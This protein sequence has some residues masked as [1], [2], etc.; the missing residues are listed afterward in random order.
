[1]CVIYPQLL[2][3]HRRLVCVSRQQEESPAS[4]YKIIQACLCQ[5][6]VCISS[7]LS[8]P[9]ISSL[10]ILLW[11]QLRTKV[12][13]RVAKVLNKNQSFRSILDLD[14]SF[15]FCWFFRQGFRDNAKASRSTRSLPGNGSAQLLPRPGECRDP[16]AATFISQTGCK[17]AQ[18]RCILT[19][20]P[21]L[22]IR[23]MNHLFGDMVT[24][25]IYSSTDIVRTGWPVCN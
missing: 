3:N 17:A 24:W 22:G 13:Q 21:S 6:H 9:C 4:L 20:R 2:Q 14:T 18:T 15:D 5:I 23:N 7:T 10:T 11:S 8:F 19:K 25:L 1:M 12:H 16:G